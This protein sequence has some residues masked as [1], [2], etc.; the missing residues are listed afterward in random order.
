[1]TAA[2]G[3]GGASAIEQEGTIASGLRHTCLVRNGAIYCWGANDYGQ[4]GLTGMS[5]AL[6]PQPVPGISE[7]VSVAA[8]NVH[9]CAV[10]KNRQVL[11]WGGSADGDPRLGR[12]PTATI[13]V[14]PIPN[15]SADV[16]SGGFVSTCAIS[17]SAVSCWGG[18][19]Y[20]VLGI[21]AA[22]P[23]DSPTPVYNLSNVVSVSVGPTGHACAVVSTDRRAYCWGRNTFGA[24]GDGTTTDSSAPVPVQ[25]LSGAVKVA[26]GSYST[27]ALL[28]TGQVS[29]WGNN[30]AGELGDGTSMQRLDASTPDVSQVTSV[31]AGAGHW[32]VVQKTGHVACW[33]QN[34]GH[35]TGSAAAG[36]VLAPY[37]VPG[38]SDAV[39]VSP[40]S[41][42]TCVLHRDGKASCWGDKNDVGQLGNGT[43]APSASPTPVLLP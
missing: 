6:T 21:N 25:N 14:G 8:G 37:V 5:V 33:G 13:A 30:S 38:I 18:N 27:C 19:D 42:F 3:A 24:L 43:M 31:R 1:M 26:A 16:V 20:G 29:C 22:G 9:T 10:R 34:G 15:F 7:A 2:G 28:L 23:R 17:V 35:Q 11:C 12:G 40:G 32:C 41:L 4:L 36:N 39:A